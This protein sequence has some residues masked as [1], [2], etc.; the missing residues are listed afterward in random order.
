MGL[1]LVA[2]H[3]R[4]HHRVGLAVL[5]TLGLFPILCLLASYVAFSTFGLWFNFAA[6]VTSVLIDQLYRGVIESQRRAVQA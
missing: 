2:I 3:R 5:I 4:L 1:L 6:V